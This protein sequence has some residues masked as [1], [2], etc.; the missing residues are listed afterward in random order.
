MTATKK[1][2]TSNWGFWVAVA[3]FFVRTFTHWLTP[4]HEWMHGI[5]VSLMGGEITRIERTH[6]WFTLPD[7][8]LSH[9]V[10]LLGFWLEMFMYFGIA[11]VFP[12]R[13]VGKAA[14]GIMPAVVIYGLR[15]E[16]FTRVDHI[17]P[18]N[19]L[20]FLLV[21]ILLGIAVLYRC[22]PDT[23]NA[24]G[25]TTQSTVKKVLH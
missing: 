16:D 17:Y 15:S 11:M 20:I 6:I 10:V 18:S 9:V 12:R 3:A 7:M 5:P 19:Y 23:E 8:S 24:C 4:M 25:R 13:L 1:D 14:A 2:Q 22:F 21:G